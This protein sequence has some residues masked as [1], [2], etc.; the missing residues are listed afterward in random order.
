M[1]SESEPG[2]RRKNARTD[3]MKKS[4]FLDLKCYGKYTRVLHFSFLNPQK[5]HKFQ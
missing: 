3:E 4:T 2:F 5:R 1:D